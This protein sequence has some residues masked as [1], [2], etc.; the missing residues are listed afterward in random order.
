MQNKKLNNKLG[1][2]SLLCTYSV[3]QLSRNVKFI[4]FASTIDFNIKSINILLARK[5]EHSMCK[6]FN[7]SIYLSMVL[8][9]FEHKVR[10]GESFQEDRRCMKVMNKQNEDT[11]LH[12]T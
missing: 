4:E 12:T 8:N 9:F 2:K 6:T 3:I 10:S 7:T 1:F 5:E 11:K